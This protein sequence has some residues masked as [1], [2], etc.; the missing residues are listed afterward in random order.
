MAETKLDNILIK[1]KINRT[2]PNA[3]LYLIQFVERTRIEPTFKESADASSSLLKQIFRKT[4]SQMERIQIYLS[5]PAIGKNF[6][7][8]YLMPSEIAIANQVIEYKNKQQSGLTLV[9]PTE[10]TEK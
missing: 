1:I 10:R 4:Y 7:N 8:E 3:L 9:E 6:L 5:L 2:N